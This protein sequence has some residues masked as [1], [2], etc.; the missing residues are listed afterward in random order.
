MK[1][2]FSRLIFSDQENNLYTVTLFKKVV[3]DYKQKARSQRCDLKNKIYSTFET[4]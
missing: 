4:L 1:F 3:D 2:N